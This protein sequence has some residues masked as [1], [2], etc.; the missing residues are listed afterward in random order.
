[1]GICGRTGS[2]KSTLIVALWRLVEP[3]G[4]SITLDGVDV[5]NITLKDLRSRVTCIPQDPILFSG[6]VRDNLDPF[7]EHSDE[8]L[9]FALEAVQLKP[10]VTEHGVGLLALVA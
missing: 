5:Q 6:N 1:M 4:G 2:G 3:C 10:A 7:K 9:W 8:T